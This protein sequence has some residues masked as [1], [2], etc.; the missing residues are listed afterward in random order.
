MA[1]NLKLEGNFLSI[2]DTITGGELFRATLDH[3]TFIV[4]ENDLITFERNFANA[5]GFAFVDLID[6][7]TELAFTSVDDLKTFLSTNLGVISS[8]G[9][10][11]GGG[12]TDH[13]LLSNI[14]TKTH[15]Q[16]D[17]HIANTTNPHSVTAAQVGLGAVNNTSDAAKPI[18][19][20]TQTALDGKAN[21]SHTHALS[22]LTQ[23]GAILNQV[24]QWNGS[25][26]V[27]ATIASGSSGLTQMQ[28]EGLI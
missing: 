11:G 1:Y 7:R 25:E 13:T 17:T 2:T 8:G 18:S 9:G 27:P 26:W 15:A 23:S 28:V 22:N 20:A 14:G 5:E 24:V 10:G 19:T 3:S 21:S 4:D 6:D 16:I 12:V